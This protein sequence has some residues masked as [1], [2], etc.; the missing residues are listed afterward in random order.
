MGEMK[1]KR[2]KNSKT[3]INFDGSYTTEIHG[4]DVHYEDENGNLHNI[5]T[6]L[7]DE[8]DFDT[9]DEP[10]AK[11]GA[12]DFRIMKETAKGL[13]KD[14]QLN[15]DNWD[16]QALKVPFDAKIPRNFRR[17]YTIGKGKDKLTFKPVSASPSQGY[18]NGGSCIEYQDVWNDADVCLEMKPNGVKETITLKTDRAPSSFSFEVQGD[19]DNLTELKLQDAW[20]M[21][22][23]GTKRD[24]SQ[25][26][27]QENGK[28]YIDLVADVSGLVYPIEIDPTVTL[29]NSSITKD[30]Y[31]RENNKDSNE[32]SRTFL[33]IGYFEGAFTGF[34]DFDLSS[35]GVNNADAITGASVYLYYFD[36]N[37]TGNFVG[38]ETYNIQENWDESTITFNN[39]PSLATERT[40]L[41]YFDDVD[42]DQYYQW[43]VT[44]IIK[45][46][47]EGV[48]YGIGFQYYN[49]SGDFLPRFYSKENSSNLP[50]IEVTYNGSPSAPVLTSPNGGETWNAQHTI[51]W[52]LGSD[53]E[54]DTLQTE[55][56]LSTDDGSSWNTIVGLTS[57][58][59]TS[60]TYDFS[61]EAESSTCRIRARHYDGTTY[62]PWDE[63]DGVFTIQHNQ[64][65]NKANNLTPANGT[66]VDRATT[67]RLEWDHQDPNSND[68][69]SELDLQWRVKGTSTW[70][71]VNQVTPNQYWDAPGGTFPHDDIEWRVRTYD[72]EG[73]S[74]PYSDIVTFFAGDKPSSATITAP[75][76]GSTVSVANPTVQWSSSNQSSYT[77]QVRNSGGT[78]VYEYTGDTNKAHTIQYDLNNNVDYTIE[79][80]ITN[81]D[82]LTSDSDSVNVSVS[83]TA[84]SGSVVDLEENNGSGTIT[85]VTSFP[86]PSGTEPTVT[87]YNVYRRIPGE[88]WIRIA[89]DIPDD[90]DYVDFTV[91]SNQEYE[92]YVRAWGDNDTYKDSSVVQGSVSL[93]NALITQVNRHDLQV[94]L[95]KVKETSLN[96]GVDRAMKRFAGRKDPVSYFGEENDW[97]VSLEC[98]VQGDMNMQTL[99][100]LANSRELLL[101]RDERG[102]KAFIT[103]ASIEETDLPSSY[104]QIHLNP[105]KTH[106]DER[107]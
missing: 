42:L 68:P 53:P 3:W 56:Q 43:N 62:S 67:T 40:D 104:Y 84:P 100:Q 76:D 54:S 61:N 19:I 96:S 22:T 2:T 23:Q 92:Y 90:V 58:G 64:A 15:R 46:K 89:K 71:N 13:K 20:L 32:G 81:E 26:T 41:K 49:K 50:Y 93:Q 31:T 12:Q 107:V 74:G 63:S 51:T 77:L 106:Y 27:R 103:L 45:E 80:F 65:P 52:N 39:A 105:T 16:F 83:Y 38:I 33:N 57:T 7:F 34:L 87:H 70:N 102:R 11:E 72:Q 17:G 48:S 21:D 91:A 9:I 28:T 8:A 82:G 1:N 24:V 85:L 35:L 101:Y 6:D 99:R 36:Y 73:L 86:E 88:E 94:E 97:S 5:N 75:T 25:V 4:S 18:V 30:S 69:Q 10:V 29:N 44:E 14:N 78:E 59:A 37:G 66:V 60:Y 55:L 47:I 95:D 79:L 98:L